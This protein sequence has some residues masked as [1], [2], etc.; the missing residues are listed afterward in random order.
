MPHTPV[1][2]SQCFAE[3]L[4]Q[5]VSAPQPHAWLTHAGPLE[6]DAQSAGP[7]QPHVCI[8]MHFAPAVLAAQSAFVSHPQKF[9]A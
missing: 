2:V 4:V 8:P 7:S 3:G 6:F 1:A 5:S 9:P